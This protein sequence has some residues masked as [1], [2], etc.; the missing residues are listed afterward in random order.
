MGSKVGCFLAGVGVGAVVAMLYAP[1][2]EDN[3]RAS[4]LPR[5]PGEEDY[6][7]TKSREFIGSAGDRLV[8]TFEAGKSAARSAFLRQ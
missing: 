2:L 7:S 6:V 8:D 5:K 3:R 1:K 4:S